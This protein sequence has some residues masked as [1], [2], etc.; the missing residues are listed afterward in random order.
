MGKSIRV[1]ILS[2]NRLFRE[3]LSRILSNKSDIEAVRSREFG[4]DAAED[5]L[6]SKA[7]V[8]VLD[9]AQFLSAEGARLVSCSSHI[10]IVMVAV[11][12]D[13]ALFLETVRQGVSGYVPKDAS[14]I[15]V[16]N[17]VRSV[18]RGEA[19]CPPR[20]C[21]YL[22]EFIAQVPGE[23][24]YHESTSPALLTR[25]EE[26]L[27]PLI[28]QG[29]SN[30]EIAAQLN[31]SEKTVKNHIHRILRKTGAESRLRISAAFRARGQSVGP[32]VGLS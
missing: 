21:K 4:P 1:C 16:V 11:K 3:A 18:A 23:A 19:V 2:D 22:F 14:A 27:V 6:N 26:Q 15:D 20:L 12:E 5:I 28:S 13:K 30:K 25:R 32:S 31:V 24:P 29:F 9:S 8:L 7:D 17:A 10:N